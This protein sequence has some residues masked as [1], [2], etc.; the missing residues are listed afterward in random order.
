[1]DKPAFPARSRQ[2]PHNP[3]LPLQIGCTGMV[4]EV[5]RRAI[6]L[7]LKL[8]IPR[9]SARLF[10][11]QVRFSSSHSL[12][13]QGCRRGASGARRNRWQL[14]TYTKQ[15]GIYIS[16]QNPLVLHTHIKCI[17]V[18]PQTLFMDELSPHM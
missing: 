6:K 14:Q 1:M 13:I 2:S 11:L 4:S 10:F 17:Q 8:F 18:R 7:N 5:A 12:K 3:F 9:L 15:S 16:T